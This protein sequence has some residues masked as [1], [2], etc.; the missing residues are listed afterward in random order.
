MNEFAQQAA[1]TEAT[2]KGQT[3]PS[4]PDL[5]WCDRQLGFGLVRL[6][7]HPQPE[8][9]PDVSPVGA[10]HRYIAADQ[11]FDRRSGPTFGVGAAPD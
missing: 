5:G 9:W 7:A 1:S 3:L 11:Y 8:P 4:N 2:T 10:R 6:L